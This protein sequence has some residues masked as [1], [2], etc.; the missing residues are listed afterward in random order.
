MGRFRKTVLGLSISAALSLT[1]APLVAQQLSELAHEISIER[2][3][4]STASSRVPGSK[5]RHRRDVGQVVEARVL[6][7]E[8]G[9]DEAAGQIVLSKT[10]DGTF[11]ADVEGDSFRPPRPFGQDARHF[12]VGSATRIL[13]DV[14]SGTY[15][16][17]RLT[18]TS[19]DDR[20]TTEYLRSKG[21]DARRARIGL[22]PARFDATSHQPP[23]PKR[24]PGL[25]QPSR[26]HS[27]MYAAPRLQLAS[28]L[29]GGYQCSGYGLNSVDGLDPIGLHL[30]R[31]YS[32]ASFD[33]YFDYEG[34]WYSTNSDA[35]WYDWWAVRRRRG[36]IGTT[37][38]SSPG[39]MGTPMTGERASNR[40]RSSTTGI[41]EILTRR[42]ISGSTIRCTP[43]RAGAGRI[44]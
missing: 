44:R 40:R 29:S 16:A 27:P 41:L 26:P 24:L 13:V 30:S 39:L 5:P 20:R 1:F 22:A 37:I 23:P 33:D 4:N 32:W 25:R 19:E 42:H 36:P 3:L 28:M 10:S 9:S 31:T 14:K 6:R 7:A 21:V 15:R 11:V 35:Y 43:A 17:I 34:G 38:T 18:G 12:S 2:H 8:A